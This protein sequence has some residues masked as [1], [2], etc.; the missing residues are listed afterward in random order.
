MLRL[1]TLLTRRRSNLLL[2]VVG[3]GRH[4]TD[5]CSLVDAHPGSRH[6]LNAVVGR[7]H[8]HNGLADGPT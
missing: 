7:S 1:S 2:H 3:S 6:R 8:H 4:R 5:H